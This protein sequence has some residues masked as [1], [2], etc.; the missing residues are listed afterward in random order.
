MAG[1]DA[2]GTALSR[3]DMGSS[4]TFTDVANISGGPTGPGMSKNIIDVTAHDSPDKFMEKLGGL[5]DGGEVSFDINWD[6]AEVTHQPL[7]TDFNDDD[8]PRDYMITFPDESTIDF[9]GVV[10]GFEPSAPHDD[11]LAASVTITVSGKPVFAAA[12]S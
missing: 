12:S 6:P 2:F 10:S 11:K 7:I 1:I 8:D 5:R 9:A 4:P 3:S